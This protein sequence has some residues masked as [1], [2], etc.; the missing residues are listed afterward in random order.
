M[1]ATITDK[2]ILKQ[3]VA[4]LKLYMDKKLVTD[5]TISKTKSDTSKSSIKIIHVTTK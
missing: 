1:G 3:K 2:V 5:I 4:L